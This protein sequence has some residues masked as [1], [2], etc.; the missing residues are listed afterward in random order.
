MN[1]T[2]GNTEYRD[3]TLKAYFD[4]I[5]KTPLLTPEEE[6]ELSRRIQDGAK[7][8]SPSS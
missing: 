4:Q 7:L 8:Q 2:A 6:H 1:K 3:D 5:K